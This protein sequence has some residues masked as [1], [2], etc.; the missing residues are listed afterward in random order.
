MSSNEIWRGNKLINVKKTI[1]YWNDNE[2]MYVN[3]NNES[4]IMR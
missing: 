3:N 4:N 1:N 2:N